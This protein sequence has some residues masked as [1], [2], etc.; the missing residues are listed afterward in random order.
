MFDER[1]KII[2]LI[3]RLRDDGIKNN[4]I[5]ILSAYSHNNQKCFLYE[6][7][8]PSELCRLKTEGRM[9][10]AKIDEIRFS[11][12]SAFKGLE[13]K[14]LILADVDS[15]AEASRKL[16]NYVAISRAEAAL[17]VFYSSA[18]EIERQRMIQSGYQK[19]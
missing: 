9:W 14:V 5:V 16:L 4:E 12:I 13:S 10:G 2:E 17:F 11:T 1:N 7:G 3:K 18:S 15:F 6:T 19:I 8:L